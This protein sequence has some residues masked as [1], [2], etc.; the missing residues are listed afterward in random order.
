MTKPLKIN[1]DT[2]LFEVLTMCSEKGITISVLFNTLLSMIKEDPTM[3][4]KISQFDKK[5]I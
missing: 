1:I 4:D 3:I 5:P 2:S